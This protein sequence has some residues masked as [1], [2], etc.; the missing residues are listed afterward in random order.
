MSR[1]MPR[2]E[3]IEPLLKIRFPGVGP[4]ARLAAAGSIWDLRRVARR[5]TP[6]AAFDYTDGAAEDE[7]ALDR[8][9]EAY[10]NVE[11]RDVK[12]LRDVSEV[13]ATT[14]LLGA[15]SAL[16]LALA[17]TG[18]TRM[19]QHEGEG[20][21]ARA[22]ERAGL[23][24]AL[25]TLGTTTPEDVAAAAPDLNRWFQL[26]LFKD[27]DFSAELLHRAKASGYSAVILTVDTAVAGARLRDVRNGLTIPP[28]L[29]LKTMFDMALHPSWWFNLLTTEPLE[30]ATFSSFDG[31]VA[32]LVT[33]VFDPGLNWD[34]VAW[35][36]EHWDG[37]LVIKGVQRVDDAREAV[38]RGADGVI[39]SNHGGRQLD[40]APTTFDVLPDIVDAV[41]EQIEVYVDG[42]VMN[43]G[44]VVAA[45][46]QG[47]RAAFIGRAYLYALM[48][49]GEHGVDRALDMFA[50]GIQR[51][52]QLL[53]VASLGELNRG[54]LKS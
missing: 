23:T 44:D 33:Q 7:I 53:G 20:A 3:D 50:A 45:V 1:R 46:A 52:M 32:E 28:S 39:V 19:M 29:T 42:G 22:A 6:R 35:M 18:F 47:A 31:T 24:Y 16:P 17:P 13:D 26:Y 2:W 12:V 14:S 48:A 43:G 9:R 36:R 37:P 54:H 27:R 30:F 51:T 8:S 5:R 21:V 15:P 25:S 11:W 4:E 34:D 38:E 40:R 10:R 41:G 49:G